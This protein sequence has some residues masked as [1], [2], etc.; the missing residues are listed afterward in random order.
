MLNVHMKV[1]YFRSFIFES[2][3][4]DFI[5]IFTLLLYY[6]N[7]TLLLYYCFTVSQFAQIF[8]S[9]HSRSIVI[10]LLLQ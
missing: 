5:Y 6:L 8:Q 1:K 2:Y 4:I 7:F 3:K 10:M 9:F